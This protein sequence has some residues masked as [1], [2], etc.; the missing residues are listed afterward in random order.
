MREFL[1]FFRRGLTKPFNINDLVNSNRMDIVARCVTNALFISHMIRRDTNFYVSLNGPP[2][3][4]VLIKFIGKELQGMFLDEKSVASKINLA[5]K[6]V[7]EDQEVKVSEGIYVRK[8]SFESFLK[9]LSN[10]RKFIYLDE[11]GEDI[12]NINFQGN[13]LFIIG[14]IKGIPKKVEKFIERFNV[15]KV[16]LGKISY[17]ASQAIIL[18]HYELDRRSI[19]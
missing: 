2:R 13:E 5:L 19:F 3:P 9:E 18:V 17:L 16:S 11:E 7:K 4:P 10:E 12:R 14:D 8:Q 1:L 15:L 6:K